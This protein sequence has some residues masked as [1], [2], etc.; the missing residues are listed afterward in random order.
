M[1][2]IIRSLEAVGPL[3]ET[4]AAIGVGIASLYVYTAKPE[5]RAIFLD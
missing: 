1:M 4:I 5:R 2:R 3:V